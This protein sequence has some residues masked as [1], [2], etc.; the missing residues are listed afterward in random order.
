MEHIVARFTALL[1][2]LLMGL[3][4]IAVCIAGGTLALM[5]RKQHPRASL[6]TA[7]ASAIIV[8]QLVVGTA[9]TNVVIPFLLEYRYP[10]TYDLVVVARVLAE[11]VAFVLLYVAV[12][13]K[14]P[15][16]EV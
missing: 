14:R 13:G 2:Q 11:T 1:L 6:L 9:L 4:L 3:P 8:I 15:A 10:W 7:V 5:R 16:T 12:L